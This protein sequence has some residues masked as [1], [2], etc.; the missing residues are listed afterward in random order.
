MRF[1]SAIIVSTLLLASCVEP[2]DDLS[3]QTSS[4]V[5]GNRIAFNRIA[6][7]RIA[8]NRIA[9]N[10]IAFNRLE[11]NLD[12]VGDLLDTPE[13]QEL[14][15]FVVSCALPEGTILEAP[16][17]EGDGTLEFH[18]AIGLAPSWLDQPM[19]RSDRR[20]VSA[21]LLARVNEYGITVP[22]SLRGSSPALS[23]TSDEVAAFSLEEGAF[24]GDV[25]VEPDEPI[26]AFACRG[27]A[28][29]AGETGDLVHRDCTE[30][31]PANPGKTICGMTFVGDCADFMLPVNTY[32]CYSRSNGWYEHCFTTPMFG[33]WWQVLIAILQATQDPHYY[34]EVITT[35]VQP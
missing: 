14:F 8:F 13:G 10:R 34:R 25:F 5:A 19:S 11:A 31:D 35:F 26:Q 9:F 12:A 24:F 30:P 23:T 33:P 18:G 3:E 17:P 32:A 2:V 29:V 28:Q 16:D 20:W 27:Q 1:V 22:V 4:L 6:F 7:N 15:Q 21:C